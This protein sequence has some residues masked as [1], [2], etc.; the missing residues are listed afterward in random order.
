MPCEVPG[1]MTGTVVRAI[2]VFRITQAKDIMVDEQAAVSIF[3]E[4]RK[5]VD[6][7]H[8]EASTLERFD[9]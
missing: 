5:A 9:H 2:G 4:S 8:T 1:I 3:G 7:G 6:V